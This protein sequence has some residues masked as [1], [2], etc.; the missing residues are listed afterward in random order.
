MSV[1]TESRV[2]YFSFHTGKDKRLNANGDFSRLTERKEKQYEGH[3]IFKCNLHNIY[4]PPIIS[5]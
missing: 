5:I 3:N 2:S 4:Y 1:L